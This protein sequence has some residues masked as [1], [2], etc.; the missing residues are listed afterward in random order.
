LRPERWVNGECDN[1]DAY[2]LIGFDAGAR[3][4][5]GKQLALLKSKIAMIKMFKRY[6]KI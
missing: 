2:V 6:K 3:A 5:P 4:C 1:L